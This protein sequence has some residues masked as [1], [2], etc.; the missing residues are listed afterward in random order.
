MNKDLTRGAPSGLIWRFC[1]PLFFSALVQQLY[2][3][4][5]SLVAGRFIGEGAL[6]AVGNAYQ[7]TLLYQALAFGAAMGVSVVISRLFGAGKTGDVRTAVSTAMIATAV[8]CVALT[9]LGVLA[10]G[11]LLRLIRTPADVF[12]P[13]QQYL[14]LY[15][16]GLLSLFFFQV[17]LGIFTALGDAKTPSL[18]L[19]VSSIANIALDLLF[20]VRFGLGVAGIAFATI[21]CQT[22]S[23][24]IALM[25][26]AKRLRGMQAVD[27]EETAVRFSAPLLKEML[28]IALPVTLQQLIVPVG[29]VLIQAN[30]NSFGSAV[31]A[32]YAAAVKMNNMA[33]AALMAFDRG[34]AAFAAQNS[35]ANRPERIRAGRNAAVLFSVC[36]GV[37]IA[38]ISLVFRSDL[39]RLFLRSG[40]A[41]ALQAGEQFFLIVIPFYLVVSIKIACDGVLRGLGAMRQLLI[42]T[43]VDLALRVAC[44]FLLSSIW[45]SIG[46]W[47]AWPV[48]WVTGTVL[49]AAFTAHALRTKS[50]GR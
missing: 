18:F 44:G 5:D 28:H 20:V 38:A 6:A 45:G 41:E 24:M 34:M 35:G 9:T 50:A 26:L 33:I 25:I 17:P 40:S 42:G 48:G 27:R 29:N 10:S 22:L 23:A 19:S 47:A 8:C 46:I 4:T 7:V 21:L 39:L 12:L 43:F 49:A 13:S 36:F 30:V 16:A 11:A 3:L 31:S 14:L 15:T 1:L 37:A 2:V 32:G